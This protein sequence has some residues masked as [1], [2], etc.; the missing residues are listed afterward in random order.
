M[1][2]KASISTNKQRYFVNFHSLFSF[3]NL[4]SALI[5][6]FYKLV[7]WSHH[8]KSG[9]NP[10]GL[11]LCVVGVN[12]GSC[13][14]E[15]LS[16]PVNTLYQIARNIVS[17]SRH[18]TSTHFSSICWR[19]ALLNP[20]STSEVWIVLQLHWQQEYCI[21][22]SRQCYLSWLEQTSATHLGFHILRA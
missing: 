11:N 3:S 15:R 7:C 21:T 17:P 1:G 22:A 5:Y 4:F 13:S 18:S 10:I 8:I 16:K 20:K 14:K 12:V 19:L 6:R 9:E 2:L